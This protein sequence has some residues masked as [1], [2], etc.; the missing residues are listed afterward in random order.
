MALRLVE[1]LEHGWDLDVR[2]TA[3]GHRERRSKPHFLGIWRKY[4]NAEVSEMAKRMS[5]PTCQA[6][7]VTVSQ[8]GGS[9]AYFGMASEYFD[10]RAILIRRTLAEAGLDPAAYGY[11]PF[12]APPRVTHEPC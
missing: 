6:K 10:C 1:I 12:D 8:I 7:T 3:C 11:P 4:L 5:C 2:C 9:Y